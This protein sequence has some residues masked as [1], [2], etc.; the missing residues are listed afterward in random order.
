LEAPEGPQGFKDF[1]LG[2]EPR[3]GGGTDLAERKLVKV[4]DR[5]GAPFGGLEEGAIGDGLQD[6]EA[7]AVELFK[8]Q[9]FAVTGLIADGQTAVASE[10]GE[11]FEAGGVLNEGGEEMSADE[12]HAGNGAE[13]LDL[14]EGSAGLNQ[15]AAGLKLSQQ[16]LIQLV[17]EQL[18]L[19]PEWIMRQLFQPKAASGF[20]KNSGAG[21][22]EAPMLVKGFDLELEAGLAADGVIVGLGGAFEEDAQIAGGLPDRLV[23][24]EPEQAGQGKGVAAVMLVGVGTDEAIA[25]GI[26]DDDLLE[27]R[28]EELS[29]PAGQVGFFEDESFV[30]GGDGLDMLDEGVGLGTKAPPFEFVALIV[31][32]SEDT[33]LGVGIQAQPCYRGRIS[34]NEPFYVND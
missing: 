7:L 16:G 6:R 28:A 25:P 5:A 30:G 26:A 13:V 8:A 29:D 24:I 33:I 3:M 15:E 10:F 11:L 9:R 32:V 17:V 12:A 20:G 18:G 2:V 22:E 14:R 19:G 31:E 27:V 34:H 23:F 4:P 21:G 1:A